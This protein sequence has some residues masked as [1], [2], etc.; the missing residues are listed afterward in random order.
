M[1]DPMVRIILQELGQKGRARELDFNYAVTGKQQTTCLHSV[2]TSFTW[3][4]LK[5]HFEED[6]KPGDGT[7]KPN[8]KEKRHLCNSPC[9]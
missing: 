2:Q 3:G 1:P 8:V 9:S 4:I 6:S 7:E 5:K